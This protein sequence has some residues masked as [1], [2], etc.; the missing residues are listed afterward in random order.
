MIS[1]TDY[2]KWL[3]S[4]NKNVRDLA[5]QSAFASGSIPLQELVSISPELI[6]RSL[7]VVLK[8]RPELWPD[9]I[10]DVKALDNI[11]VRLITEIIGMVSFYLKDKQ[12]DFDE[13]FA[14]VDSYRPGSDDAG[15]LLVSLMICIV[16]DDRWLTIA[17]NKAQRINAKVEEPLLAFLSDRCYLTENQKLIL[18]AVMAQA[19]YSLQAKIVN[20]LLPKPTCSALIMGYLQ[21]Y[22]KGLA[23][24][25][26]YLVDWLKESKDKVF[27][28]HIL[29]IMTEYK[30]SLPQNQ[31][32]QFF[33]VLDFW[34]MGSKT[35]GIKILN[36]YLAVFPQDSGKVFRLYN[37]VIIACH[38][39][40]GNKAVCDKDWFASV[41]LRGHLW[42]EA[43]IKEAFDAKYIKAIRRHGPKEEQANVYV[44]LLNGAVCD[45]ETIRSKAKEILKLFEE[46]VYLTGSVTELLPYLKKVLYA[47][48]SLREPVNLLLDL[49]LERDSPLNHVS[50]MNLSEIDNFCQHYNLKARNFYEKYKDALMDMWEKQNEEEKIIALL[51]AELAV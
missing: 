50:V 2:L 31:R 45:D 51:E 40:F 8:K 33:A 10:R 5:F 14:L 19:D 24:Y 15:Q 41:C 20:T 21:K 22:H 17:L 9:F 7:T 16:G 1:K 27:A 49:L 4:E 46:T 47:D 38:R 13:A 29:K 36:E 18:D 48:N 34:L 12:L 37:R 35:D 25:M 44:L 11:P 30:V 43:F 6:E 3:N 28:E 23:A 42:F 32:K 26:Y 39:E